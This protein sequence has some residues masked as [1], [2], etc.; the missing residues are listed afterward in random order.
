MGTTAHVPG[1][2]DRA[3]Q[4]AIAVGGGEVQR[5]NEN[6]RVLPRGVGPVLEIETVIVKGAAGQD[7][8]RG[9]F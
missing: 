2:T 3:G 9:A 7:V 4:I 6:G 8:L 1:A 5:S